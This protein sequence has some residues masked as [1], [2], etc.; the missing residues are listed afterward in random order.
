MSPTVQ[1]QVSSVT[2]GK[3]SALMAP[4]VVHQNVDSPVPLL[5]GSHEPLCIGHLGG[6][7]DAGGDRSPGLG[8]L[9][10]QGLEQVPANVAGED[11][12]PFLRQPVSDGPAVALPGS[13]DGRDLSLKRA[14]GFG[15]PLR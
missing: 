10:F 13:G 14:T 12:G 1:S 9:A 7:E 6:V 8:Y 5:H 2:W 4:A 15:V 11:R 3:G